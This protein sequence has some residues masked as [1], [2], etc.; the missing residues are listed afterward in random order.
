MLSLWL[1]RISVLAPSVSDRYV[2]LGTLA[3]LRCHYYLVLLCCAL[4]TGPVTAAGNLLPTTLVSVFLQR[5]IPGLFELG[6]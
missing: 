4:V 1:Q 3:F 6:P 2:G 5:K